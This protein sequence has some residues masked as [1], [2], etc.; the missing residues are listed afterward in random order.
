MIIII[1]HLVTSTLD[2]PP[3]SVIL[4]W[5]FRKRG[6]TLLAVHEPRRNRDG[7]AHARSWRRS[8][9]TAMLLVPHQTCTARA[10]GPWTLWCSPVVGNSS[11]SSPTGNG[12]LM[13]DRPEQLS[14]HK[15]SRCVQEHGQLVGQR[16]RGSVLFCRYRIYFKFRPC[17]ETPPKEATPTEAWFEKKG[18]GIQAANW[19]TGLVLVCLNVIS[20][21][22]EQAW[23]R[24]PPT[25]SSHLLACWLGWTGTTG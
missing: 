2:S 9:R 10:P 1:V 13:R 22:G 8:T 18:A 11:A 14:W 3:H 25:S 6:P 15:R 12:L 24:S 4:K 21:P 20:T 19:R 23:A 16:A 5:K 7:V 17:R